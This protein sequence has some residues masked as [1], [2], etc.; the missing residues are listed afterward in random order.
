ME[1]KKPVLNFRGANPIKPVSINQHIKQ[2]KMNNDN[3]VMRDGLSSKYK[4]SA[5]NHYEIIDILEKNRLHHNIS[6][7]EF[8]LMAGYKETHYS[9][10]TIY[11]NRFSSVS[12]KRYRDLIIQLNRKEEPK[13]LYAPSS[14]KPPTPS[15]NNNNVVTKDLFELNEENCVRFLKSTGL[16]KISKSEVTTNWIEL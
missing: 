16:Y 4:F 10:L 14:I 6:K 8:S 9:S 7:V 12:Y 11:R 2:P 15:T 3:K 5:H 13:P 1:D